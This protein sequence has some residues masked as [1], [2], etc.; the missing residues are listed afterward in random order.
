MQRIARVALLVIGMGLL[1]ACKP[2]AHSDAGQP[3]AVTPGEAAIF[4]HRITLHLSPAKGSFQVTDVL[5]ANQDAALRFHLGARFKV[6]ANGQVLEPVRR[7]A[8]LA[9]YEFP[10]GQQPVTLRYTGSIDSTPACDWLREPCRLLSSAGVYLDS[11]SDWYPQAPGVEHRFDLRIEGLPEGWASLSQGREVDAYHWREEHPQTAIYVLAGPYTVYTST[12]NGREARVYLLH[13]DNALAQ[14]YLDATHR[15]LDDYVALLGDY[16][17]AKFATVESFWETGW[18]MPSFTLL[19]SRVMRLPF[20]LYSSFPHEILHN[21]WGNGVYVDARAGNW[22]EGLTAY[23][24]DHRL[25]A[26]RHKEVAYRRDTLQKFALFTRQGKDFPLVEF[27]SRHNQA[28]QAVGYGKSMMVF[29]MLHQ[30]LGGDVFYAGLKDFYHRYRFQRA[31]F[32]ALA[33]SLETASGQSL[34]GFF[35]Q[36]LERSGAPKLALAELHKDAGGRVQLT[37]EQRQAEAPFRISV[38]VVLRDAD[39]GEQRITLEMQQ[40]RQ[41]WSLPKLPG[42]REV[43]IDPEFD[44]MR[45]PDDAELPASLN[46]LYAAQRVWMTATSERAAR[47]AAMLAPLKRLNPLTGVKPLSKDAG[48]A[49][50][51]ELLL[52]PDV[53]QL[54]QLRARFSPDSPPTR[55]AA[56]ADIGAPFPLTTSQ[57]ILAGQHYARATHSAALALKNSQQTAVV[58]LAPDQASLNTLLR[59]LPH[60]GKY[61]YVL[62]D[63][64]SG[65]NL[66]KGQW[67]VTDSPLI[68]RL[69]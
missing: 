1:L 40:R 69:P 38:P 48:A 12:N 6:H 29:H 26:Q 59:K 3:T 13:K 27:R 8:G 58:L 54:E 63:A 55:E 7:Q 14:R 44:L 57:I 35:Q 23:L 9:W 37:L 66:A 11:G 28:T 39:G 67:P 32:W 46:Q 31:D 43:A 60:Y 5:Q 51:V 65:K 30:Q 10:A 19:G 22:S 61:S 41:Q 15:Y 2:P 50:Q 45:I 34:Q 42:L 52:N 64:A 33:R 16:P 21:W 24:A 4:E 47:D 49:G 36:W 56:K 25:Q 20:I 18:G 68:A 17:Y 62:F 53:Q